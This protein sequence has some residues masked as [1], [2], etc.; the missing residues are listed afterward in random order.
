MFKQTLHLKGKHLNRYT[1][2]DNEDWF[3]VDDIC[4]ILDCTESEI[5][6]RLKGY[7]K[8]NG[9]KARVSGELFINR[10]TLVN[11]LNYL[12]VATIFEV[13]IR[14]Q[15]L[16]DPSDTLSSG[17]CYS[18]I[19]EVLNGFTREEV[20]ELCQINTHRLSYL[21]RVNAI[22]PYKNGKVVI[23]SYRQLL[24]V[25]LVESVKEFIPLK[26][27]RS[28]LE[29]IN[30]KYSSPNQIKN[31]RIVVIEDKTSKVQAIPLEA[32]E[33]QEVLEVYHNECKQ[34]GNFVRLKLTTL[35][36]FNE[37]HQQL[38]DRVEFSDCMRIEEFEERSMAYKPSPLQASA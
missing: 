36:A 37:L 34:T 32:K 28:A 18:K 27:L 9:D 13:L 15:L 35:P 11:F 3:T 23:Y 21:D 7:L 22:T 4:A 2:K 6:K 31:S 12:S 33:F 26:K 17:K 5:L 29:A 1:D 19:N 16:A 30:L 8:H 20:A 10:V 24:E 14:L 38:L 25:K